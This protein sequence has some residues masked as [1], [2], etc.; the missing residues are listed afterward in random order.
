MGRRRFS[1]AGPELE[2]SEWNTKDGGENT[3]QGVEG[4]SQEEK[5]ESDR[6]R[7]KTRDS[8]RCLLDVCLC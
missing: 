2:L 1:G 4:G 7:G 5:R 3:K 6:A 8:E